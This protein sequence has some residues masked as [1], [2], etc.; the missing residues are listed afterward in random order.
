MSLRLGEEIQE[1]LR[2][3]LRSIQRGSKY[4]SLAEAR[5]RLPGMNPELQSDRSC[6]NQP[7]FRG[8][9]GMPPVKISNDFRS[10]SVVM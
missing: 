6:C 9:S 2:P 8:W 1:V 3:E 7:R 10:V 4:K 5:R